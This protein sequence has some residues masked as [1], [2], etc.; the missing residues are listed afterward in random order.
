MNGPDF[1][2]KK[3]DKSGIYACNKCEH[4][5][6]QS[7]SLN[8]HMR[9]HMG[10]FKYYCDQCKQGFVDRSNYNQHIRKHE[11]LKYH[12]D[13]CSKPFATKR[14]IGIIYQLIQESTGFSVNIVTRAS[15]SKWI[16]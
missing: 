9:M 10:Q 14:V 6:T 3:P 8:R 5:F 2:K 11:W 13:Y 12:C 4:T 7:G 15:T 16:I 1:I